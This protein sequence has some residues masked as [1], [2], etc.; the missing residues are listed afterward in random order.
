M[1]GGHRLPGEGVHEGFELGWRDRLINSQPGTWRCDGV[2][3]WWLDERRGLLRVSHLWRRT[4]G[5]RE[6]QIRQ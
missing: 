3:D 5:A 1:V 6:D 2:A 4:E